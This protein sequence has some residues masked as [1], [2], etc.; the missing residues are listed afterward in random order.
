MRRKPIA[1]V[2]EDHRGKLISLRGVMGIA[3]GKC[4][5]DP[6]IKIYILKRTPELLKQIPNV[7]EGYKV[8][9]VE[10]GEFR[11]LSE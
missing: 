11:A 4:N 8:D 10:S 2:L 3:A 6:C 9:I 5:D 1:S 7:L